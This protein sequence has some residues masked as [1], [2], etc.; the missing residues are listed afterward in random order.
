MATKDKLLA[1]L[2]QEEGRWVSGELL[3][4]RLGVSRAAVS[5]HVRK[6]KADGYIIESSPRKGYVLQKMSD[7]L[8]PAEI[9][10]GLDTK[11]FGTREI[12]YLRETDSTNT[13]AKALAAAG[14]PEG[15]MVVAETQTQGRG[16][17]KRTWFSPL[18]QG[19]YASLIL[20]PAIPPS[21]APRITLMTAVAIAEAFLALGH[22]E[23]RIKWP[24]DIL[25]NG[26]K[27]AGVLTEI[28][29]EMDT[30]DY[31]MVGLGINVNTP[32]ESF[33]ETLKSQATSIFIET[34]KEFPR[35]RLVRA[36]LQWFEKC[37]ARFHET[38]F[39]PIIQR[40]K[41]LTDLIGQRV[42]VDV[43]GRRYHGS[44]S[45]VDGDGVLILKDDQDRLHRIFSGDLTVIKP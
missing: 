17:K 2:K 42:M 16:R 39:A 9:Q 31:I 29:T 45:D 13:R 22:S 21:E 10:E 32:L 28:S 5:K 26:K 30:I 8:L 33:D 12:L 44:V 38:G 3:S 23:I 34:G 36:Y 7:R 43:I 14:A 40:W 41:E 4:N 1:G 35:I 20:R 37:Y 6:L 11:I 25:M 15:T 24:N 27:I 18:G 19:I